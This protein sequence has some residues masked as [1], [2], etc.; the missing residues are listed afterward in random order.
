MCY[1]LAFMFNILCHKTENYCN[2]KS[3]NGVA[4]V[5]ND[6]E[7]EEENELC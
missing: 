3:K 2:V 7:D 5:D 1:C 6:E 4:S